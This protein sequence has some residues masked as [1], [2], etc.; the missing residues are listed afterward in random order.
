MG[1]FSTQIAVHLYGDDDDDDDDDDDHGLAHKKGRNHFG[2]NGV[3]SRMIR[4]LG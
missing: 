1:I 3:A 4:W 2:N